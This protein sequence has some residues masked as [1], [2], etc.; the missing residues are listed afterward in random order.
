MLVLGRKTG[1]EIVIGDDIRVIVVRTESGR[2]RLGVVAPRSVRIRRAELVD[3]R[4]AE[5]VL[6]G[7]IREDEPAVCYTPAFA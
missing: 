6:S 4:E 7:L 2:V 3:D 5:F 1:E